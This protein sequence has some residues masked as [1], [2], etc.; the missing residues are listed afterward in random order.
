MTR[1]LEELKADAEINELKARENLWN[2]L[3]EAVSE[4][5]LNL[6][7][8]REMNVVNTETLQMALQQIELLQQQI[9]QNKNPKDPN[10]PQTG[11]GGPWTF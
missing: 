8:V 10:D 6:R 1:T 7:Q 2:I 9:N 4:F 3:Y 11:G 5:R